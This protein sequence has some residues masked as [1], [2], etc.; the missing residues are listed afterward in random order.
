LTARANYYAFLAGMAYL[1]SASFQV[2]VDVVHKKQILP[3]LHT[4]FGRLYD[5]VVTSDP[6]ALDR[7]GAHWLLLFLENSNHLLKM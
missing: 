4:G 7:V 3:M 2:V 5:W 6:A 1:L